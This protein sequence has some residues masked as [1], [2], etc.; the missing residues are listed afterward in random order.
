[1]AAR[2][3][4]EDTKDRG[5]V[6]VQ[7]CAAVEFWR[8]RLDTIELG[9]TKVEFID[10]PTTA[11]ERR[12]CLPSSLFPA[13]YSKSDVLIF[14]EPIC[15]SLTILTLWFLTFVSCFVS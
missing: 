10:E 9:D 14:L 4:Q 13:E 8:L 6:E 11:S 5:A 15:F 1:M 3:R 7:N 12:D 2:G